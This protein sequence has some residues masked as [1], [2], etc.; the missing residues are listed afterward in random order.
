[1]FYSDTIDNLLYAGGHFSTAGG[2]TVKGIAKWN[3]TQWDS[4]GT[5]NISATSTNVKSIL[6][7]NGSIYALGGFYGLANVAYLEKW[8]GSSWDS[9][10]RVPGALGM[11]EYSNEIYVWGGFTQVGSQPINNIAKWNGSVWNSVANDTNF[12]AFINDIEFYNGELYVIGGFYDSVSG[13]NQIAKWNGSRWVGLGNGIYN[14]GNDLWCLKGYNNE[15]YV[16]GS[17]YESEG[18][19][20]NY[21]QKWDGSSWSDVGGGM[22]GQGNNPQSNATVEALQIH[23][24]KLYACG[25]FLYSGGVFSPYFSIW[26]GS[27][28]CSLGSN[29]SLP[30]T[31]F[32]WRS[33]TLHVGGSFTTIDGLPYNRS[34]KWLGGNFVSACGNTSDVFEF[35]EQPSFT[36]YPNPTS[37]QVTVNASSANPVTYCIYNTLGQKME[38][39]KF[40][41]STVIGVHRFPKG[42]YFFKFH[43]ET[44]AGVY[45]KKLIIE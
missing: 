33:D 2:I 35:S 6:R 21:I 20:G 19:A 32:A 31:A 1:V 11:R 42:V 43:I 25:V 7:Y 22:A 4:M 29:F 14:I 17:F 37:D 30:V 3:G 23:N 41:N 39:G 5:L 10:A 9:I 44:T 40:S 45:V 12:N 18:N 16:G 34:A 28:W 15:L 27:N 36:L 38:E 24:G 8:N 13:K 26:D